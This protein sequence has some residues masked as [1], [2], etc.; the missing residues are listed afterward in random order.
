VGDEEQGGDR[1]KQSLAAA[2][3]ALDELAARCVSLQRP[4]DVLCSV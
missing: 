1:L 4:N 3:A 2:E